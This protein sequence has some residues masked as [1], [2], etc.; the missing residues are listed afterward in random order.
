MAIDGIDFDSIFDTWALEVLKYPTLCLHR[1]VDPS[2]EERKRRV[3]PSNRQL[4]LV[5]AHVPIAL[6]EN[7]TSWRWDF[8]PVSID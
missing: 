5:H 6:Q 2:L 1:S 7:N 4:C 8:S 3:F